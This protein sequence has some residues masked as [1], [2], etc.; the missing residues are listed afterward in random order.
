L[1]F[2]V[3]LG[4]AVG[5]KTRNEPANQ[6]IGAEHFFVI[7]W[8]LKEMQL[9]VHSRFS[10]L[11]LRCSNWGPRSGNGACAVLQSETRW[12]AAAELSNFVNRR[13]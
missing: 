12:R 6:V 4:N 11:I 8:R 10:I 5:I 1:P 9:S 2:R 13:F 3:Q 7:D